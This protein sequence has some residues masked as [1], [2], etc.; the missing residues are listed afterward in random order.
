MVIDSLMRDNA[1]LM[2]GNIMDQKVDSCVIDI[3]DH[4]AKWL[5]RR[6]LI[7]EAVESN[8]NIYNQK[9]EHPRLPTL[10]AQILHISVRFENIPEDGGRVKRIIS[11]ITTGTIVFPDRNYALPAYNHGHI[12][13][14]ARERAAEA[15]DAAYDFAKGSVPDAPETFWDTY[16]VPVIV[17]GSAA[18]T[19]LLLFTVRSK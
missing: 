6:H 1:R 5:L 4:P 17:V 16:L 3:Q 11:L 15:N 18:A 8:L 13:T 9:S 14:L 7:S 12:D 19:V 2:A 10:E